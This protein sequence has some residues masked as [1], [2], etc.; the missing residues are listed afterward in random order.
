MTYT[1]HTWVCG[2][3]ITAELLNNIEDGIEE[4][5]ACCGGSDT[6]TVQL[7]NDFRCGEEGSQTV[8]DIFNFC[9]AHKEVE[10]I[11]GEEYC[12]CYALTV[13]DA[14]GNLFG[15]VGGKSGERW[16]YSNDDEDYIW[17]YQNGRTDCGSWG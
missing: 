5:L 9:E 14:N 7:G 1:R 4:A 12:R 3:T 11:D 16:I 13:L 10:I 6:M 2:E 15:N 8:I 17:F